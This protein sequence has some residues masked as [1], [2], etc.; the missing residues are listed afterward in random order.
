MRRVRYVAGAACRVTRALSEHVTE[1]RTSPEEAHSIAT[2][3]TKTM[4]RDNDRMYN[5]CTYVG[6]KHL[7]MSFVRNV[8]RQRYEFVLVTEYLREV[9]TR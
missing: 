7:V 9:D 6:T 4:R 5:I 3:E 1:V 2:Q 8:S